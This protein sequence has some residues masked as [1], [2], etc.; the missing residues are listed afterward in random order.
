MKKPR[1]SIQ[2]EWYDVFADWEITDQVIAIRMISEIHR[3][4]IRQEKPKPNDQIE[5]EAK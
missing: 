4:A 5:G 3:Q 1:R 2:E